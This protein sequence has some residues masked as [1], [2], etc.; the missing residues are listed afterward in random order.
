MER[1]CVNLALSW[2]TLVSPSM[3]IESFVGYSSLGWHLCSLRVCMTSV[4]DHLAFIVSGVI[5]I[6]LPLYV[7]WP[8]HLLLLSRRVR[9]SLV[10]K[11]RNPIKTLNWKPYY[12]CWGCGAD[13]CLP[14]H[15]VSVSVSSH[16]LW[17]CWVSA[18]CPPGSPI[19]FS[20]SSMVFPELWGERFDG[21]IPFRDQC[22]KVSHSLHNVWLCV[23]VFDSICCK[24]KPPLMSLNIFFMSLISGLWRNSKSEK[25]FQN[26]KRVQTEANGHINIDV[27]LG[28]GRFFSQ[29]VSNDF[30]DS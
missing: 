29:V 15:A 7:T 11:L 5:L 23:S 24:E 18:P 30:R 14:V 26:L 8:F 19:L 6:G 1:Y 27:T 4:Q 3:V 22:P 28:Q 12:K 9:D 16:E 17:S 2:N 25:A 10:L 21:D 20:S 13:P